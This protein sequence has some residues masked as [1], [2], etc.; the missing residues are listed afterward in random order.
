V[1]T[2]FV[3][4][5]IVPPLAALVAATAMRRREGA[6]RREHLLRAIMVFGLAAGTTTHA[7]TFLRSG[8]VPVPS[9]PM[10][11]N[12]FW[13]ALT[14]VD[15]AIAVGIIF[16]PRAGIAAAIALMISDVAVNVTASG[17][18]AEWAIWFQSAFGLFVLASAP[19]CWQRTA[20]VATTRRS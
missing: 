13:S 5:L 18:F 9:L 12:W 2:W 19:Y 8:L 11:Y 7:L 1:L 15:P 17:G 4:Q 16:A 20:Q 3:C 10:A 6:F 14:V